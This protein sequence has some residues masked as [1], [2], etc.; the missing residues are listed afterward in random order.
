MCMCV[1]EV[2][3]PMHRLSVVLLCKKKLTWTKQRN[4]KDYDV[5]V[6]SLNFSGASVS[7]DIEVLSLFFS[8]YSFSNNILTL[9]LSFIFLPLD[10]PPSRR[11]VDNLRL[12]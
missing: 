9:I 10:N 11:N 4:G 5:Y 1:C 2:D 12:G 3:E 6:A 8:D 7:M